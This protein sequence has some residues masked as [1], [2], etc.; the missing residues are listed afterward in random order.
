MPVCAVI[1]C[2]NGEYGINKWKSVDCPVHEGC[3][4]GDGNCVCPPPY[5]LYPFSHEKKDPV[6]RRTWTRLINRKDEKQVQF[7][8]FRCCEDSLFMYHTF[9]VLQPGMLRPRSD[10]GMGTR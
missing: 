6:G 5:V 2:G 8:L 1:G 10:L 9:C 3:K 7:S 4:Q